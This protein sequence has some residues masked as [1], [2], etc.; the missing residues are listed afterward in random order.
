MSIEKLNNLI[1]SKSNFYIAL[2]A[3]NKTFNCKIRGFI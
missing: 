2:L 1:N 3:L